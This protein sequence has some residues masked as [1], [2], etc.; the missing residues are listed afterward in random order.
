MSNTE[1]LVRMAYAS[2]ATFKPFDTTAGIDG[3]VAQILETARRENKKHA[4]VGALYYGNG[5]FFQ[6]L[7]GPQSA[8]DH[9]YAK[10]LRDGRH[11]DLKILSTQP[12]EKI[13]FSSWEMKFATIDREI[14][15]FLRN[16]QMIKFDP[17]KFDPI[18]SNK[19]VEML[20]D[21]DEE[22]PADQVDSVLLAVKQHETE[23]ASK[24][25]QFLAINA[26]FMLAFSIAIYLF[27]K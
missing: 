17:Y 27:L 7:E 3:N 2:R 6:C 13:G 10:L 18:M 9:L 22:A 4:L 14:R 15:N 8:I 1:P 26:L 5:Y 11:T 23:R 24:K 21:A 25:Y 20:H 19:L 12:I 16:H